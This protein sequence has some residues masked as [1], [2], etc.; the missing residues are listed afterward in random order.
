MVVDL[1]TRLGDAWALWLRDV[2]ERAHDFALFPLARVLAALREELAQPRLAISLEQALAREDGGPV[3]AAGLAES[4]F[5]RLARFPPA[6]PRARMRILLVAPCSGY[7]ASVLTPLASL[8]RRA[9]E[10]AVVEWKDARLVPEAAG[11]FDAAEQ[12]AAVGTAVAA[13]APDVVVAVSQSGDAALAAV[14]AAR[15]RADRCAP[16][17]LVL[18]GCPIDPSRS[19]TAL[20]QMLAALPEATLAALCL[21]RVGPGWPGQG[22]LVFPG[23]LQLA[24][25]A[26]S[27]PWLVA[28]VRLRALSERLEGVEG[29]AC[30]ALADLFAVQDVPGELWCDLVRRLRRARPKWTA[31]MRAATS[32]LALLTV[33]A[34]ADALVGRGQTHA[35]HADLEPARVPRAQLT[36]ASARHHDLF[37]GPAFARTLAPQLTAFLAALA[38]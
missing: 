29:P 13:F 4:P 20:Q 18:L 8:L 27:E 2:E 22:R 36:V 9:G 19:P 12:A 16:R 33:E 26:A 10:L 21:S 25:I 15:A 23:A 28:A 34:E 11:R 31:E 30:R 14:L 38:Q 1:W 35:L 24:T 32:G 17:A 37:T 6:Q 3:A 7:A 5:F